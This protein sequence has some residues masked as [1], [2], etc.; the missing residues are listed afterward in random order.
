MQDYVGNVKITLDTNNRGVTMAASRLGINGV[1]PFTMDK[2]IK[3]KENPL[4]HLPTIEAEFN[5]KEFV[6]VSLLSGVTLKGI[7]YPHVHTKEDFRFR[8]NGTE[9][10]LE[11]GT[12]L[13]LEIEKINTPTHVEPALTSTG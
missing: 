10:I 9:I 12:V 3:T 5:S 13:K 11:K 8:V 6:N 1:F 4:S 7:E 2:I